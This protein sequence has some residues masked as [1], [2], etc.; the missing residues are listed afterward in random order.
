MGKVKKL[1]HR[2]QLN[3]IEGMCLN[4]DDEFISKIYTIAHLNGVCE[5][6]HLEWHK[7]GHKIGRQLK[8]DGICNYKKI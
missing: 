8:K 5:N 6:E 2:E 7:E 3:I 1:T 4:C